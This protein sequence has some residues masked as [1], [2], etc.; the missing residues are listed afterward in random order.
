MFCTMFHLFPNSKFLG[1]V[2]GHG[3]DCRTDD[4]YTI[5][6]TKDGIWNKVSS[7]VPWIMQILK[8]YGEELC[9]NG[10]T[11]KFS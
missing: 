8:K 1:T 6:G 11:L 5:E 10:T 7:H 3:Y 2:Q 4:T 9:L